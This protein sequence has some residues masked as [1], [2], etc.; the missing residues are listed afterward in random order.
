MN[1]LIS[2]MF[3]AVLD[4]LKDGKSGAALAVK[5]IVRYPLKA[6]ATLLFAPLLAIRVARVAK[7]P[8]RR[9]IAGVGLPIAVITAYV[10][11]T[12]TGTVTFALFMLTKFGFFVGVAVVMSSLVSVIVSTAIILMTFNATCLLFLKMSSE[13]VVAHLRSVSQ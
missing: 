3:S 10:A 11:G 12:W 7:T 6:I 8:A 4:F 1:P 9:F 13:D 5:S 2:V